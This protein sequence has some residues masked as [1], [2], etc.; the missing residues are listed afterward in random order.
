MPDVGTLTLLACAA[1]QR[2]GKDVMCLQR[3]IKA[4]FAPSK[5][6]AK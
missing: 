6:E 3:R 4:K 5:K 2:L 1:Y